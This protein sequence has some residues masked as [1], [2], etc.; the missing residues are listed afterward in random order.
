MV[1]YNWLYSE[2]DYIM[3]SSMEMV[4]ETVLTRELQHIEIMMNNKIG[5]FSQLQA[6]KAYLEE[7]V[8][9]LKD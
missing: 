1:L 5:N 7:R 9:S 3:K 8:A 2:G 4:A 6:V